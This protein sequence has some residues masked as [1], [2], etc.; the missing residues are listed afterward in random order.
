MPRNY[1]VRC[2]RIPAADVEVQRV[3]SRPVRTIIARCH[4]CRVGFT[5]GENNAGAAK[6]AMIVRLQ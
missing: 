5:V 6:W 4:H 2:R 3:L 1:E